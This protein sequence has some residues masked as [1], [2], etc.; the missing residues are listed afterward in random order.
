MEE[1]VYRAGMGIM[2][3]LLSPIF[4]LK[5]TVLRRLNP[6]VFGWAELHRKKLQTSINKQS[7]QTRHKWKEMDQNKVG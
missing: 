6:C 1:C 4:A 5:I 3:E 2:S 7:S